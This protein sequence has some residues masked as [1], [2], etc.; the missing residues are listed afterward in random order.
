MTTEKRKT[1]LINF[2]YFAVILVTAFLLLY[3]VMP[4]ASPFV[5]GFVIAWLLQR[6]IR[7]LRQKLPLPDKLIAVL[8]V[9]LFYG[10]AGLL[11]AL[12]G[13][14]AFSEIAALIARIPT[15]Y[16]TQVQPFLWDVLLSLENAFVEMDASLVS[17]LNE[18]GNQFVKSL[19]ERVTS[20]SVAAMGLISGV[21]SSL[22]ALFIK[23]VLMIISTFFI[24]I[25]YDR[26]TGFC[27]RQLSDRG[28]NIFVQVKEYVAG[29]LWV[30]IRSYA[31][32][33]SITFVEL[34]ILLTLIGIDHSVLVAFCTAIFDILPVLGT[35]GI[36]I[37]WAVLTAVSG[38]YVLG[39]KLAGVYVVVTVVR[40]IIEPK[41]V[42]GQLGLHP[43]VTLT[44]M[45]V[46]VQLL[47]V[48]GL[49]GFPIGL[50]LLRYLNDH[51]VIRIFK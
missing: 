12:L 29:T 32:I 34:S 42:G 10:T 33:M 38:N 15:L 1:F 18:M 30:C 11:L 37:P 6:P 27:L 46:G 20:W 13:I 26:L 47:G 23:L 7:F 45:F 51:G 19:G 16:T 25:D 4:L 22:P 8:S 35:G 49:F 2:T 39:L 48:V 43:I 14:K 44:S 31:L 9:V 28:K 3:F 24:A 50:S 5:I 41:I 21:A 40:N 36:M 17:A